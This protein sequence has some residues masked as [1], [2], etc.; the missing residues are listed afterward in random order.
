MNEANTAG[1]DEVIQVAMRDTRDSAPIVVRHSPWIIW[2]H[3]GT[4]LAIVVAVAAIY[5]R[6][7]T[8]DQWWR[9]MFLSLHRQMGLLVLV[10]LL[11]RL[12]ARYSVK[13]ADHLADLHQLLRLGARLLQLGLYSLLVIVPVLGWAAT[14]AHAINLNLFGLIPLPNLVAANTDLADTLDD[15][16]KWSSWALGALVLE[17]TLAALF[18]HFIRKDQ[19][20][21]A[22]LPARRAR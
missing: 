1:V 18:H 6:E 7:A 10:G 12:A 13:M 2:L 14:N 9:Q 8:E 11:L 3:W 20:L 22:M 19:V 17:H 16:H 5:L 21:A 15:F 4:T